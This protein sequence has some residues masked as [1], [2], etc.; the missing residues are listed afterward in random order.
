[1]DKQQFTKGDDVRIIIPHLYEEDMT[2]ERKILMERISRF[3][4]KT[5][6]VN[7]VGNSDCIITLD[8]P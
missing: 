2:P 5:G 4:W 3:H 6:K 7:H 8:K 1:M